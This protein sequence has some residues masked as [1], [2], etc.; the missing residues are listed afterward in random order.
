MKMS[1]SQVPSSSGDAM[2]V[3]QH[4]LMAS[5]PK[6]TMSSEEEEEIMKEVVTN[7]LYQQHNSFTSEGHRI[8]IK[9]K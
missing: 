2:D 1:G 3:P 5:K 6:N 4:P 7:L 8:S 9:Q